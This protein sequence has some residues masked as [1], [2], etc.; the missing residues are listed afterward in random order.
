MVEQYRVAD[1]V[2]N[3]FGPAKGASLVE[4]ID[5]NHARAWFEHGTTNRIQVYLFSGTPTRE[6][7]HQYTYIR[8][9]NQHRI[10]IDGEIAGTSLFDQGPNDTPETP[11]PIEGMVSDKNGTPSAGIIYEVRI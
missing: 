1:G 11:F 2:W 10:F 7:F 6:G 4:P 9:G 8:N 5:G 3:I